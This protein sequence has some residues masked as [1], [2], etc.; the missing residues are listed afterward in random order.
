MAGETPKILDDTREHPPEPKG[1]GLRILRFQGMDGKVGE[2]V[3]G[4][5]AHD[6]ETASETAREGMQGVGP[7]TDDP[8][9]IRTHNEVTAAMLTEIAAEHLRGAGSF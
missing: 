7:F 9:G 8:K 5:P 1:E 2:F 6:E 4:A 3:L